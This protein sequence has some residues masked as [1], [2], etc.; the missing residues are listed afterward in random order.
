M[1]NQNHSSL[2]RELLSVGILAERFKYD[3]LLSYQRS[4]RQSELLKS[5]AVDHVA[6]WDDIVDEC[7]AYGA[8]VAV[9]ITVHA[10]G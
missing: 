5:I 9:V 3:N 1:L 8:A 7:L 6:I 2:Y 10:D 4:V